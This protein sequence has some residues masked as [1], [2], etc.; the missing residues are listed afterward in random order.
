VINASTAVPA[1]VTKN[2]YPAKILTCSCLEASDR[3]ADTALTRGDVIVATSDVTKP[4]VTITPFVRT[5]FAAAVPSSAF[6]VTSVSVEAR[7]EDFKASEIETAEF[8]APLVTSLIA[9]AA[10]RFDTL[11]TV[12]AFAI[13]AAVIAT[14]EPVAQTL[15]LTAIFVV[16]VRDVAPDNIILTEVP[17]VLKVGVTDIEILAPFDVTPVAIHVDAGPSV[18]VILPAIA[19]ADKAAEFAHEF[20]R[21]LAIVLLTGNGNDTVAFA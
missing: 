12:F 3:G 9:A 4:A 14:S 20:A 1:K 10:A 6:A 16:T 2:T 18:R 13:T 11:P 21:A 19:P 17:S 7:D 15:V 8:A 5:I